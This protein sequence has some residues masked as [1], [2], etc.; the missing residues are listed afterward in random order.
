MDR[1]ADLKAALRFVTCRLEEQAFRSG[2]P[3]TRDQLSLLK[4]LPTLPP[5]GMAFY[6]RD[7][8]SAPLVPRDL[9]YERLWTIGKAAYLGDRKLAPC[10]EWQFAL[11]VFKLN[12]HAMHG[13]LEEAG[14]RQRRPTSDVFLLIVAASLPVT[15]IVTLA[16]LVPFTGNTQW[17]AAMWIGVG[18]VCLA[19]T[20][21]YTLRRDESSKG[22]WRRR[23]IAAGLPLIFPAR[24]RIISRNDCKDSALVSDI[25]L[26]LVPARYRTTCIS[27]VHLVLCLNQR[28]AHS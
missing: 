19:L 27:G 7:P 20:S 22:S 12:N 11:A 9:N 10:L 4:N 18:L 2:E 17:A 25:H 21:G 8:M 5:R 24:Y 23:L 14:V 1:T 15:A 13:L 26:F 28:S 16:F 3:L 6:Y